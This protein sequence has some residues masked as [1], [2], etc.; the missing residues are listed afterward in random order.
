MATEQET[1]RLQAHLAGHHRNRPLDGCPACA[2][3]K[4]PAATEKTTKEPSTTPRTRKTKERPVRQCEHCGAPTGSSFAIGHDAKLK[5]ELNQ[6]AAAGDSAAWA[7][8]VLRDW[9][10]L[11]GK[12]KM[13]PQATRDAGEDLAK[14]T[15]MALVARR[16]LARHARYKP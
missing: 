5:S 13:P 7:E 1:R 16:N 2:T 10:K 3:A 9:A 15:G 11:T 14:K 12:A 4:A 8:L 6:K